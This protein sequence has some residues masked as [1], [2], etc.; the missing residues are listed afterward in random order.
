M[1]VFGCPKNTPLDVSFL[2]GLASESV[3]MPKP[4]RTGTG[5][6]GLE[7]GTVETGTGLETG[8]VK[9][10]SNRTEPGPSWTQ[11]QPPRGRLRDTV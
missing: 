1:G 5:E 6:T 2:D 10:G 9:T 7:T 11:A 3:E 8:D 4:E